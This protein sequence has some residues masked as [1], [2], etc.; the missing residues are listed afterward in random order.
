MHSF[1]VTRLCHVPIQ[2]RV[3]Q[4]CMC[5][6]GASISFLFSPPIRF[7]NKSDTTK[8]ENSTGKNLCQKKE[9]PGP[10]GGWHLGDLL[11]LPH[12]P[13]FTCNSFF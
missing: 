7:A 6:E 2:M 12:F 8:K 1:C 4:I 9:T 10:G 13:T 5:I 11:A 3:A